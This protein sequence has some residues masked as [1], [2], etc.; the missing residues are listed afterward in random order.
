M[1]STQQDDD[2]DLLS[3][4]QLRMAQHEVSVRLNGGRFFNR[5]HTVRFFLLALRD[6][7]SNVEIR[8]ELWRENLEER[9]VAKVIEAE[10]RFDQLASDL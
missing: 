2:F 1:I 9:S 10:V 4:L 5:N 3:R 6:S 7:V 8:S